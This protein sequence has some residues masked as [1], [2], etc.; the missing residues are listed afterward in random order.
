MVVLGFSPLEAF[1]TS[2]WGLHHRHAGFSLYTPNS[3][4]TWPLHTAELLDLDDQLVGAA[5]LPG[6]SER[7]PDHVHWSPMVRARFG[8]PRV[9]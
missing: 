9:G 6:V 4:E 2:R 1:L 3:H 7:P 5:G 8:L